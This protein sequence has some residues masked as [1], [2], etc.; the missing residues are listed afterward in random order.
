MSAR[1]FSFQELTLAKQVMAINYS[2]NFGP[3]ACANDVNLNEMFQHSGFLGPV[4]RQY[5]QSPGQLA[6]NIKWT[7]HA[8]LMPN[9]TTN[10]C[11]HFKRCSQTSGF[12]YYG[13]S[14]YC[15]SGTLGSQRNQ[16][17]HSIS[18]SRSA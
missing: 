10:S 5:H 11:N 8:L 16:A 13:I 12:L 2:G 15:R 4:K 6:D 7:L 3:S 1:R 14:N 18:D 9:T 17:R